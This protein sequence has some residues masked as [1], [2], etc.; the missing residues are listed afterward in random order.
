MKYS[1]KQ[2]DKAGD[3]LIGSKDHNRVEAVTQIINDWRS[4]HLVVLEKLES[5]LSTILNRNGI[6]PLFRSKRLKR[7]SSIIYKL[8]LN[9]E[10]HLGGMHDI[11]GLR[12][13]LESVEILDVTYGI[14]QQNVPNDFLIHKIYNYVDNPKESGYR[15]IHVVYKHISDDYIYNG[16]KVELQIR[17]KLQHNW[18]TAVETG[19][20]ATKT[21]L[22]SSQGDNK[23]LLFFRVVSSLFAIKEHTPL[24]KEFEKYSVERLMAFCYKHDEQYKFTDTLKALRETL[25][26]VEKSN[27]D[28]E[29]YLIVIKFDTGVVRVQGFDAEDKEIATTKYATEESTAEEAKKA[30]VLVSVNNI[31]NLHEAYPSYF[32]DTSEFI[33]VLEKIKRNCLIKGYTTA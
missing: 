21:S 13:V 6:L 23:W 15:S 30:V 27:Y 20:L 1:R 24:L 33:D 7:M 12:F 26:H 4:H 31:K 17:T 29:L 9:P 16:L 2:I 22:K 14:L 19:G 10:M 28:K 11:G 25:K 32:L 8:D 3:E 5:A 18:A